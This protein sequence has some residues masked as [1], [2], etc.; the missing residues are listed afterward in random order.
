MFTRAFDFLWALW[1]YWYLLVTGVIFVTE[2]FIETFFPIRFK[3][4]LNKWWRKDN[5]PR[6]FRWAAG[7]AVLL[8]CFLAFDD[9]SQ[10]LQKTQT[11]LSK[12]TGERDEAR[13]QLSGLPA[14][15]WSLS[16]QK[17]KI[18]IDSLKSA[19]EKFTVAIGTVPAA[20]SDALAMAYDLMNHVFGPAG[21]QAGVVIGG[22]PEYHPD[23]V[24][25]L[26]AFRAH[27]KPEGNKKALTLK[28]IPEKAG[29]QV[30]FAGYNNFPENE[31]MLVVGKQP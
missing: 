18:L 4:W 31:S 22:V 2:Q 27:T 13:R 9:V 29:F 24:G 25:F 7:V 1:G 12:I 3:E 23:Y 11:D 21:W 14:K 10:Q 19:P 6:H 5:R 26:V 15:G 30:R 17:K 20:P 8:A 16:D 28:T